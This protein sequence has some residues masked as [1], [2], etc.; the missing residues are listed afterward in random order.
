MP[1]ATDDKLFRGEGGY[2]HTFTGKQFFLDSDDPDQVDLR[3][4]AHSLSLQGRFT[5]HTRRHYSVAEHS[6]LVA[7]IAGDLLNPNYFS[8][9]YNAVE[10]GTLY[11]QCLLHDSTEAY[12]SDIAAPFKGRVEGYREREDALCSK[13]FNALGVPLPFMPQVKQADW[14]ALFIEAH[15]L[16]PGADIRVWKGYAE[17]EDMFKKYLPIFGHRIMSTEPMDEVEMR[18]YRELVWA[19]EHFT[20]VK[21]ATSR[22]D[23]MLLEGF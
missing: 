4:I 18:F 23:Q 8:D 22:E 10:E 2:I 12:L 1:E 9:D 5:G 17:Y 20:R 6:M 3:D 15:L 7:D 19:L 16:M 14:I 11:A 21:E 13:V